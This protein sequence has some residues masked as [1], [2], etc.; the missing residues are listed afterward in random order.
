M[1]IRDSPTDEFLTVLK[2]NSENKA[3]VQKFRFSGWNAKT[4]RSI[5]EVEFPD[6]SIINENTKFAVCQNRPYVYIASGNV[7]YVYNHKDN[8]VKPLR[9]DFGRTIRDLSLIHI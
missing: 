3:Y 6:P 1:C 2:S 5:S 7:L 4:Y 8:T 9:S